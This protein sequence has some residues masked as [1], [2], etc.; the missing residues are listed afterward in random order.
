VCVCVCVCVREDMNVVLTVHAEQVVGKEGRS[1]MQQALWVY[2][3]S[4]LSSR[5]VLCSFSRDFLEI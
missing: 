5:F 2:L 1:N 4:S 3:A